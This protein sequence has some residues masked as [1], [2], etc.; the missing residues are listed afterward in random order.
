MTKVSDHYSGETGRRYAQVK[1][2]DPRK[3]GYRL[4]FEYF[5]PFLRPDQR[6]LDFGCGNGGML[7]HIRERVRS[8]EGLEV[9]AAA[10]AT[11]EREGL[12]V[13]ATIDDLP[14]EPT[15]DLVVTNHVLEHVRDVCGTLDRIRQAMKPGAR[16]VVKLPYDDIA[17][18]RQRSWERGDL[19]FHLHTFSV[20]NFANTLFESGFDVER[21]EVVTSCWHPRL[22]P[23]RKIGLDRLA[24]WALAVLKHRRQI[25]AVGLV[26]S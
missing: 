14:R 2:S 17:E 5:E 23:L 4:N 16:I 21:C 24:F 3:L 13:H 26:P 9:N 18:R 8:A 15:Y 11:A 20:R 6:V 1:Q 12:V 22:F 7:L 10:R 19:D 25:F